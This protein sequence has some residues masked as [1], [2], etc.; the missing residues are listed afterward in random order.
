MRTIFNRVTMHFPSAADIQRLN[1]GD[2]APA[3]YGPPEIIVKI[4]ARGK[5]ENDGREYI[6]Y[7]TRTPP[8]GSVSNSLRQDTIVRGLVTTRA[9][10]SRELDAIEESAR[11]QLKGTNG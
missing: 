6:S 10:N 8:N 2:Y 11:Q 5:S 7:Y 9:F 3:S 4:F 1:V